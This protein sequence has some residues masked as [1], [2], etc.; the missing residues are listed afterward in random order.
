MARIRKIEIQNFRGIK[1]LVWLPSAGINCLIGPGDSG[2]SSILDAIFGASWN[3][4][5][6]RPRAGRFWG[7]PP[8]HAAP[9]GYIPGAISAVAPAR[10][11]LPD[12]S[13]PD[14]APRMRF[15]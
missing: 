1:E 5:G 14:Y 4:I 6:F 13:S 11:R 3:A 2:K 12:Q 9:G 15:S 8:G 10:P 7:K